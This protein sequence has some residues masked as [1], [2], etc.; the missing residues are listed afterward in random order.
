MDTL[1]R[2]A[3]GTTSSVPSSSWTTWQSW[4]GKRRVIWTSR[5]PE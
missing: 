1:C 4:A 2:H 3:H 5:R